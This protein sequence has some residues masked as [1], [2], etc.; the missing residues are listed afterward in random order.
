MR[1]RLV[2]SVQPIRFNFFYLSSVPGVSLMNPLL[3]FAFRNLLTRPLRSVLSLI[4]LTVAIMAMV[5]LFS[6]ANGLD[7]MV[8]DTFDRIPGLLAVQPGAPIP[9]FSKLPSAWGDEI[10]QVEGVSVVNAEAWSRAQMIEGKQVFSPP[11]FLFG[12]DIA[13]RGNLRRG[14]YRD[15]IVEGRF[16]ELSDRGTLNTVISRRIA[17]EFQKK[18]GDTLRVDGNNLT[19]VGIYDC[20]SLFLDVTIILD[21]DEVRRISRTGA[22]TVSAYYVELESTANSDD[23]IASVQDRFRGRELP[24][25]TASSLMSM[26]M[27]DRSANSVQEMPELIGGLVTELLSS[28]VRPQEDHDRGVTTNGTSHHESSNE[29]GQKKSEAELPLEI[30]SVADW[31]DDFEKFSADLDIF[32]IIMT[33]IGVTIAVVSILNTMLM[34]VTER[35]IEFGILKANGWSRRNIL[36]LIGLESGMLG[37]A[38]GVLGAALGW[39]ATL[40]INHYWS[41]RVYLYAGPGLLVFSVGFSVLLGVIGGLYPAYLAAR[42]TPMD[43]IR[44]A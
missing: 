38:G 22:D 19:I 9:L 15:E 11:R 7:R 41:E 40:V 26:A 5:G 24:A 1:R 21:I 6:V 35:S 42:M 4:G 29:L 43:A 30:R 3:Q 16:L 17:E 34:S 27:G 39:V 33:G 20:N 25:V 31:A 2:P 10:A 8:D 37:L 32:L 14:V 18:L 36:V 23:V 13:S 12:T 44:R 28:I